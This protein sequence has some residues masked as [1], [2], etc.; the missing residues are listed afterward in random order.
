MEVATT[1]SHKDFDMM[2]ILVVVLVVVVVITKGLWFLLV[3]KRATI[4]TIFISH[5]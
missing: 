4:T 2:V 3:L 5:Q 1:L